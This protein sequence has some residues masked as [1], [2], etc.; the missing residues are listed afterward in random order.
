MRRWLLSGLLAVG[1][2]SPPCSLAQEARQFIQAELLKTIQAR[3]A[4]VGDVVRARAV[5]ALIVRGGPTIPE[6]T[7][8]LGKVRAAGENFLAISFD[9]VKLSK[10]LTPLK[11]SIRAAMMPD[12]P[13]V[14]R[15]TGNSLPDVSSSP[16][17]AIPGGDFDHRPASASG[18]QPGPT[19]MAGT[20]VSQP[21]RNVAGQTGSVIGMPGV[22][23]Q[24]D[25]GP[26]HAS[27][28]AA[29]KDLQLRGGLQFMLAV[30]E[31]L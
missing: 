2:G 25:E 28:F 31:K 4:K 20:E 27:T 9:E 23:L 21:G 24:V 1:L 18:R 15:D 6:G 8:L 11:L 17:R 10:K 29:E 3:K 16:G 26:E 14:A 30:A 5:Q 12:G 13:Q 19:G 22:T 7:L